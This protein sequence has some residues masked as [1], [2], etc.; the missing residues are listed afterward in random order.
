MEFTFDGHTV[1]V[2]ETSNNFSYKI[3]GLTILGFKK[4]NLA[5]EVKKTFYGVSE[6]L[7]QNHIEFLDSEIKKHQG[8]EKEE[9]KIIRTSLVE[10]KEE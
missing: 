7:I 1:S 10:L 5:D 8:R 3:D 2:I 6:K 9:L 4:T